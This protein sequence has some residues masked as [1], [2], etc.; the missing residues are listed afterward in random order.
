MRLTV[1][2]AA[3]ERPSMY[4]YGEIGDEFGGITSDMFR[5]ELATVDAKKPIDL[6]LDTPG[7]SFFQ[8]VAIHSQLTQ[9]PG[10]VYV[11]V[12]GMAASAGSVVAM[13]GT[14]IT[15]SKHSAL[16][17]HE[18]RANFSPEGTAADHRKTADL[19]DA[20]NKTLIDVYSARWK[21]DP[22]DLR[23]QLS[24]ET[25]YF[26][27]AAVELGLADSVS[28]SVA[29]AASVDV[30]KP[31]NYKRVPEELLDP[32]LRFP[33]LSHAEKVMAELFP[34]DDAA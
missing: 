17:I 29:I 14:T 27:E 11:F 22:E 4:L 9:R 21:G 5:R 31:F 2:N 12:D 15:M 34:E 24:A 20:V 6:H 19:L 1:A 16:M 13:A 28:E 18:A 32:H 30:L 33:G 3:S 7:G 10:D 25:W 26:A 23:A 8:G